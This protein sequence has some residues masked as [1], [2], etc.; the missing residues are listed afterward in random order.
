MTNTTSHAGL[1]YGLGKTNINLAT[2][3]RFGVLPANADGLTE[4]LWDSFEAE[5]G[6]PQCPECNRRVIESDNE[7]VP[8][9][10][11]GNKD[12]YCPDCAVAYWSDRCFGDE[13]HG[14]TCTH[15]DYKAEIDRSNDI[16]I[17]ASP[18]F[19]YAQFC[20][21][22]APGACYLSNPLDEP[23]AS[24]RAYCLGHEWFEQGKAPYPIYS[25]VTGQLVEPQ[26]PD[27]LS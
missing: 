15:P 5:Y 2:G 9:L 10:E 20:S 17:F 12:Y 7:S 23:L 1:D 4:W 18:Y 8:S 27:S 19:T 22:C 25:V 21:P 11:R 13:P 14:H 3:I 24:N 6:D 16:W 26:A